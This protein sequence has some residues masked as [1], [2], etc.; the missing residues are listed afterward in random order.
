MLI[1]VRETPTTER[2][3]YVTATLLITNPTRNPFAANL[4]PCGEKPTTGGLGCGTAY[5]IT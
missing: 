1:L 3:I 4:D 5:V 2:E